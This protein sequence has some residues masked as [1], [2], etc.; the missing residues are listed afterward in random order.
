M[1]HHMALIAEMGF[2]LSVE[3]RTL[4]STAFKN[5][6][7]ARRQAWRALTMLEHRE[8]GEAGRKSIKGYR[9][10]IEEEIRIL[11]NRILDI[12]SKEILPHATTFESKV[13]FYKLQG[14]Y[15]RYLTEFEPNTQLAEDAHESYRM[16]SDIALNDL[17]PTNP[18][19]L[20]LALNFSVFYYEV[21]NSP[22]RACLLAKAAFDDAIAAMDNLD[23]NEQAAIL[24]CVD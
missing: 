16:A 3:E 24:K 2:E 22:E 4:F 5:A 23:D 10:V 6:V 11:C 20:G 13:F 15:R 1:V 9:A 21:L 12:L 14:D 19:R 18:I 17:P 8:R 7:G